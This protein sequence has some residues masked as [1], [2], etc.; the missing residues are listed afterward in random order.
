[1][2]GLGGAGAWQRNDP[3]VNVGR[4]VASGTRIWVY[5]GHGTPGELGGADVPARVLESITLDSNKNFQAKYQAAGGHNAVF[6]FPPRRHPQ[7]GLLGRAV[8]G[9]EARHPANTRCE[10]GGGL[11]GPRWPPREASQANLEPHSCGPLPRSP[12]TW[13]P[14]IGLADA[15]C[16]RV[17]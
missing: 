10:P 15:A 8:A 4:L 12:G 9:H 11:T 13:S 5:C 17:P 16:G 7:L 1:M 6:N 3:T 14:G 2:W